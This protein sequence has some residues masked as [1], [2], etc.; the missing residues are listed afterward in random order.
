MLS[1]TV[2]AKDAAGVLPRCLGSVK[3]IADDIVVVVDP[4][5]IDATA[6]V[7]KKLGARVFYHRFDNFAAQ[8]NFAVAKAR[9]K[10]ILSLDADE[11]VSPQ[12]AQE[13]RQILPTTDRAAFYIPRLNY[14]FGRAMRHTNWEP[15]ADTH[16]WLWR[17]D[18]GRWVG[19]V[20]EEV[21]VKGEVQKLKGY[22]IH[23]NYTSVEQ[24]IAK[25]NDYT[26]REIILVNP[27]VD[28]LRRYIWHRGFLDGWHGLFLSYLMAIY[29]LA[30][31]V[32]QW[33]RKNLSSS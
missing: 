26:S 3:D 25:M 12:L 6:E 19:A 16:I 31:W 27:V 14:I 9:G 1:V 15:E 30:V 20:H 33:E 18:S 22:K 11:Q 28:F 17:K 13:I 29:H 10:W 21:M 8:K 24:F 2:I 5:T 23:D 4:Q 32:K 7:A